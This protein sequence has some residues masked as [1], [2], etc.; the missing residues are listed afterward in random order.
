MK[1]TL[2]PGLTGEISHRIVSENLVSHHHPS[3]PPVL[4]SP[5]L[6]FLMEFAAYNAIRP[7]L[8][9]GEDSV[10][11]GFE[12]QHLAPTPAGHVV[13]ASAEVLAIEGDM[14]TFRVEARDQHEA[15]GRG[16]HV[17][18]VIELERFHRRLRRKLDG[19]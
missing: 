13:V 15:I 19:C 11:V 7:H 5:W 14:V 16:T 2:A 9:Q 17:R 3:G 12:F 18:A 6:L 4:A 1:S 10:G 8:D